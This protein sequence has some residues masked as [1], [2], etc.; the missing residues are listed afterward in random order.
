VTPQPSRQSLNRRPLPRLS[1]VVAALAAS[2][3]LASCGGDG[4]N[5]KANTAKT[6]GTASQT[7]GGA[8]VNDHGAKDLSGKATASLELDDFYFSPTTL[9]GKPG[10]K[11]K[12]RLENEGGTEHN[13]TVPG[14]GVDKD[15]EKG[16]E[17][18]VSLRF[19]KSGTLRFF[20]KYHAAQG[21]AGSLAA[22]GAPPANAG[23][24]NGGGSG[25]GGSTGGG[26]SY[27]GY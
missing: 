8:K 16:D 22:S 7:T 19:P 21:M 6:G 25:A 1:I 9:R 27:G 4:G 10:Q 13:L 20:C 15:L 12:L 11:L 14:Q 5:D 3:A 26:R 18:T 24:A 23:A 2:L 17:G